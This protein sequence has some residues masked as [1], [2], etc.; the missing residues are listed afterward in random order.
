M[1][2]QGAQPVGTADQQ[3]AA[4]A[5]R[6]MFDSI[7]PRYDFL[8]HVLSMNIDRLW[9]WRTARKFRAVLSRPD[10]T[11]L[12]ICCGTGDMTMA[13]L[14][15]RPA[16]SRPMLAADFAHQML[17]RGNAKFDSR[18]VFAVEADALQL[19][20]ASASIDLITTAF[21]FR[22][23]ANYRAGL[24]EFHRV[25]RPGGQFGILDFGEPGGLLGRLYA[26]YFRR[27]LP[28]IGSRISGVSGPYAYLPASV[29]SFPPPGEMLQEMHDAGFR[30]VS[31]KPYSFGIAG[32]YRGMK[33]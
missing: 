20:L 28:A 22:N 8:N 26:F 31:W 32:L 13:L 6:E 24:E 7:A 29:H 18:N 30:E 3:S 23:L 2:T 15:H 33:P 9:W 1:Q 25:L 11:I 14:R 10:A 12:D 21:G 5:V 17:I 27:I 4:R 16:N 19:P